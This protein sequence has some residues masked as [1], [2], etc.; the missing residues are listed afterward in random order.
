MAVRDT[1]VDLAVGVAAGLVATRVTD[2]AQRA[3]YRL[4]PPS[5]KAREPDFPQGSSAMVAAQ[6]TVELLDVEPDEDGLKA[7]KSAI[8]YGLGLGWGAL[9]GLLRRYSQMTPIGAGT[10]TGASL[11]LIIDEA[12]S[13]ALGI[14]APSRCYPVSSHARGLLTHLIYGLVLAAVAEGLYRLT[15]R[16]P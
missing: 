14:T 6:K 10:V 15:D 4:T 5:E 1:A 12:L 13:P 2:R 3:L 8:H 16:T 9:Y 7:L 11:S